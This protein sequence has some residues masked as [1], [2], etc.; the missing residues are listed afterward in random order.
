MNNLS[1]LNIDIDLE[2]IFPPCIKEYNDTLKTFVDFLRNPF[3]NICTTISRTLLKS[4]KTGYTFFNSCIYLSTYLKNIER[5]SEKDK[6]SYCK[7]FSFKLKEEINDLNHSCKNEVDCYQQMI[8]VSVG[9]TKNNNSVPDSCKDLIENIHDDTF[10]L[11]QTLEGLYYK[12]NELLNDNEVCPHGSSCFNNYKK[13]CK[14][15][16]KENNKELRIF[17][18]K[19]KD[20]HL[21]NTHAPSCIE[22]PKYLLSSSIRTVLLTSFIITLSIP[23]IAFILYEYT[24]C[25]LYLQPS[26]RK[27]KEIWNKKRKEQQQLINSFESTYDELVDKSSQ[28]SYSAID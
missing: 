10:S 15:C 28:I 18:E 6:I 8:S 17:L 14:I 9:N 2:S 22:P 26:I 20:E 25:G 12:S 19:Y 5:K 1:S 11:F 23:F 3:Y 13:L 16:Q 24:P 21:Q 27:L 7:Y 4:S